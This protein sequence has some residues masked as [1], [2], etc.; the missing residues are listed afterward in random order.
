MNP[1]RW[2]KRRIDTGEGSELAAESEAF[3]LGRYAELVEAQGNRVP[4]WAW[5]NLLAHGRA[6]DLRRASSGGRASPPGSRRWRAARGYLSL[7]VLEA[8]ESLGSLG[9]VQET[10]LVPLELSLAGRSEVE[11]WSCSRW[12]KAVRTA[13]GQL[14][15]AR[16]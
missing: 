15:H 13:L 1:M 5:T 16:S 10:V 12:V 6:G 14:R 3:L 9:E 4:V 2:C 7:E 8:A 11:H